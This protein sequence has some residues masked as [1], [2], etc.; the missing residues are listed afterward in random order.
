MFGLSVGNRRWGTSNVGI[1]GRAVSGPGVF[2][3][4]RPNRG[5][6]LAAENIAALPRIRP[7]H[8]E[9]NIGIYIDVRIESAVRPYGNG[10]GSRVR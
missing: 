10:A 7:G 2:L 5:R 1:T 9:N 4:K 6:G 8:N 3:K